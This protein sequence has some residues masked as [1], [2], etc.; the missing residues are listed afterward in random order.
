MF[1]FV[2]GMRLST[3]IS[4]ESTETSGCAFQ[5][6]SRPWT[7]AKLRD[8]NLPVFV[9]QVDVLGLEIESHDLTDAHPLE[10]P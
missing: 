2:P 6:V 9:K 10:P 5:S 7:R 1:Y 4:S 8:D 3:L